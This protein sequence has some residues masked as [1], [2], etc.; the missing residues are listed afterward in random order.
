MLTSHDSQVQRADESPA[1]FEKALESISTKI[2]KTQVDLE[3]KRV[4]LRWALFNF[5][6]YPSIVY[7]VFS[8]VELL[9]VKP[10]NLGIAEWAGIVG[11]PFL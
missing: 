9:V 2:G 3:R 10:A 11:G 7:I 5:T 8:I 4:N 6:L 1:S